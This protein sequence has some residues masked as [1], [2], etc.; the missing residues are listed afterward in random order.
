MK[1]SNHNLNFG[2]LEK[3]IKIRQNG[4]PVKAASYNLN[5]FSTLMF[6]IMSDVSFLTITNNHF[7]LSLKKFFNK[8]NVKIKYSCNSNIVRS[9]SLHNIVLSKHLF[10]KDNLIFIRNQM[11]VWPIMWY[12]VLEANF[13]LFFFFD[14]WVGAENHWKRR[15]FHYGMTD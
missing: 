1:V 10:N 8:N 14:W 4:N 6:K 7:N 15:F 9:I 2:Y 5:F 12:I 3:K 11:N 13:F